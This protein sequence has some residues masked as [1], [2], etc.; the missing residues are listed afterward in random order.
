MPSDVEQKAAAPAA[1]PPERKPKGGKSS[2]LRVVYV[3]VPEP[4]FNFAKAQAYLSGMAW[5]NYVARLLKDARPY[6]PE[7]PCLGQQSKRHTT[8]RTTAPAAKPSQ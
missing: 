6:P 5:P 2:N 1:S 7:E 8:D 3:R 4:V